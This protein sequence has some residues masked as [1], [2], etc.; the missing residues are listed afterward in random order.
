MARPK[1]VWVWLILGRD[2]IIGIFINN[3]KESEFYF[4]SPGKPQ[5]DCSENSRNI[6]SIKSALIGFMEIFIMQDY[7]L[8]SIYWP[9]ILTVD[10]WLKWLLVTLTF[11]W[12]CCLKKKKKNLLMTDLL[13]RL[14][15]LKTVP[16][17]VYLCHA[18]VSGLC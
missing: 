2:E 16:T 18:A 11:C 1:Y 5:Q 10:Y 17:S 7:S 9:R 6:L 14:A 12:L 3:A 15:V 13:I 8:K 4:E